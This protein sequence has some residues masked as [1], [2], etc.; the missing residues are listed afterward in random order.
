TGAWNPAAAAAANQSDVTPVAL[1]AVLV[2]ASLIWALPRRFAV[3]PLLVMVCLMPLGQ[4]LVLFGLHFYLFR[5]LLLVGAARVMARHEAAAVK[6]TGADRLFIWWV[7][8]S[9]IFGTMS[10][11]TPEH[12]VNR[13][14][15]AY[16]ALG[17]YFFIRCVIVDFEDT[18]IAVRTLA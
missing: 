8:V 10:K 11:L 3:C 12:F 15:D 5:L 1:L 7:L 2:M 16:N 17:C 4:Q 9:V 14:G 13:L 6:W 18:V